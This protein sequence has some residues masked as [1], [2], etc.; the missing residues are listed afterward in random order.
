LDDMPYNKESIGTIFSTLQ[1]EYEAEE[2]RNKQLETKAQV[3]LAVSGVLSS[4]LM[5]LLKTILDLSNNKILD[6]CLVSA[7]LAC[8]LLAMFFFL[9]V[10]KIE[11]FEQVKHENMLI[12]PA[13]HYSDYELKYN[14]AHDYYKCLTK[15]IKVGNR[16][17]RRIKYGSYFIVASIVLFA[18]VFADF[19]VGIICKERRNIMAKDSTVTS[20]G[21]KTPSTPTDGKVTVPASPR[22]VV[23]DTPLK[24]AHESSNNTP[25]L[26]TQPIERGQSGIKK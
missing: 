7:S 22:T 21:T 5:L 18:I 11:V 9:L 26:G 25:G 6:T 19:T 4:A 12:D 20:G 15:N 24:K 8:L 10:F 16:K 2:S 23:R 14:L 1:K 13:L 17:V 3:L